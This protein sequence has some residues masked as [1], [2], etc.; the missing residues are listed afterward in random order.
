MA[1]RGVQGKKYDGYWKDEYDP[2]FVFVMH[3]YFS[4]ICVLFDV[5]TFVKVW[6]W[7]LVCAVRL[8]VVR[9]RSRDRFSKGDSGYIRSLP[10]L[11]CNN[12]T[13]MIFPEVISSQNGRY[14]K[15]HDGYWQAV[16][17]FVFVDHCNFSHIF[18]NVLFH[19]LH[20]SWGH[21]TSKCPLGGV[22]GQRSWSIMIGRPRF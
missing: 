10:T 11:R 19:D 14:G 1:T 7:P 21:L 8:T 16:P 4:H 20:F 18:V 15:G 12:L 2:S 3:C 5:L 22:L 6:K 9:Q 13:L 17:G